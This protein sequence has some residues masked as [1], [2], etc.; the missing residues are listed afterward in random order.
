MAVFL[1]GVPNYDLNEWQRLPQILPFSRKYF[2]FFL[3]TS[4]GITALEQ[5]NFQA[6]KISLV[7]SKTD[8]SCKNPVKDHSY[9]SYLIETNCS[10]FSSSYQNRMGLCFLQD[11]RLDLQKSSLFSLIF[12][13]SSFQRTLIFCMT[14]SA[15][16]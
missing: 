15:L 9:D 5:R 16:H 11:E 7:V 4:E 14:L 12:P 2:L 3:S 13:S 10:S 8:Y 6:L 1:N